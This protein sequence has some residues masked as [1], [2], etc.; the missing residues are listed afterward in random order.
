MVN[1]KILFSADNFQTAKSVFGRVH[2]GGEDRYVV[3]AEAM[4]AGL[5]EVSML[6][7]NEIT[8]GNGFY[9][10]KEGNLTSTSGHI[11]N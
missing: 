11:A 4:F 5:I 1:D 6:V 7:G 9:V 10:D 3:I 2:I 8:N